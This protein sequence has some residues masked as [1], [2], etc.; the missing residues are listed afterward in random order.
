MG[1]LAWRCICGESYAVLVAL[2]PG[3][4]VSACSLEAL[5][6][7]GGT[8]R[9][10]TQSQFARAMAEVAAMMR[11]SARPIRVTR[12]AE[13]AIPSN[14]NTDPAGRR[15]TAEPGCFRRRTGSAE[16]TKA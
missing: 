13:N 6:Y 8:G 7:M 16:Q 10:R 1:G 4:A 14:A 12:T 5:R 11:S 2:Q 9:R 3:M 15:N